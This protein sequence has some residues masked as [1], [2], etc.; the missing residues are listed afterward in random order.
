MKMLIRQCLETAAKHNVSSIAFPLIG[1]GH[2]KYPP[3]VVYTCFQEEVQ[4][5][6]VSY[7]LTVITF[8]DILIVFGT[9]LLH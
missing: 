2:L 8:T 5:L 4:E 1:S 3:D 6:E 7:D 9:Q